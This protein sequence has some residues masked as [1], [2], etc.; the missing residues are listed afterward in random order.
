MTP[1]E[2]LFQFTKGF[3]KVI[4]QPKTKTSFKFL[5]LSP[6]PKV[7]FP[8]FLNRTALRPLWNQFTVSILFFGRPSCVYG[9][10][11][12]NVH[13]PRSRSQCVSGVTSDNQKKIFLNFFFKE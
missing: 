10:V 2:V 6:D 9:K 4:F 11:F 8:K 3:L 13:H 1:K 5:P 7:L 12:F